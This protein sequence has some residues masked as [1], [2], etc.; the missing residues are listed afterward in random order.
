MNRRSLIYAVTL[1][2]LVFSGNA[3][4]QQFTDVS[5]EAG[6]HRDYTRSWG[7]PLWGD[8]NNDGK[9]D[10]LMSNHEGPSGVTEGGTYPYI[11]INNGDGTFTDVQPTSGVVEQIAGHGRLAG[12]FDR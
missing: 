9:L 12:H 11:Y 1:A 6:L 2:V 4:A 3:F 10:W 7:N 5:V 8:F